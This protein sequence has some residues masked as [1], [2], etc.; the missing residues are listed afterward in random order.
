MRQGGKGGA[1]GPGSMREGGEEEGRVGLGAGKVHTCVSAA[2]GWKL[3]GGRVERR[4]AAGKFTE[5][6]VG[7]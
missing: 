7:W 2:C 6:G 4:G 3:H 1:G 5:G